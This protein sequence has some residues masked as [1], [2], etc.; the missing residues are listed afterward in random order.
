MKKKSF[1]NRWL[2]N[3]YFLFIF[4]IVVS[5]IIWIYMSFSSPNTNTTFTVSEVPIQM[6]LSDAATKQGLQV[7][8]TTPL[9]ASV[10][11]SGTR[12]V[13]GLVTENDLTVTAATG[14]I[15]SVDE[16]TLPVTANKRS[17]LGNFS[18]TGCTPST[19]NV[20]VDYFKE[21]EIQIQ[22]G[23]SYEVEDGYYGS[24]T[25][26]HST[27]IVSGPQTE[28]LSI[29]KVV[30]KATI[31]SK[32]TTMKEVDAKIVLLDS[33]DNEIHSDYLE[34]SSTAV[35][36]TVSVLPEKKVSVEPVYVNKPSGLTISD[37][38]ISIAPSEV[39]LAGPSETLKSIESV[40]LESIDFATLKNQKYTFE[41]LAISVPENCK[42][43]SNDSTAKVTLDLS[44]MTS[45]TFTVNQF[46]VENLSADLKSEVTSQSIEVTVV[47]PK[48]SLDKLTA[49]QITAVIDTSGSSVK[50]GSVQMPVTFQ[51]SGVKDCWASGAYLA[52][53]TITKK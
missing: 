29:S 18:V 9:K 43:I 7:F 30:A 22:D 3:N 23:I 12:T 19:I 45:K 50:T 1:F 27:L 25:L 24:T 6:Q 33:D 26:A 13:L 28:V 4:A 48:A 39:Q 2:Q 40:K 10:T 15:N 51:M 34:L 31:S 5:L 35:K 8:S 17:T 36:A 53:I 37:N 46:K 44:S 42:N 38:M 52:N 21:R 47:G 11:V 41:K 32:L 16:Y 14:S 20:K 49:S